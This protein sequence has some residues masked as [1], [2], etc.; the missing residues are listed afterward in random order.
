M[1]QPEKG[2]P[3]SP[4]QGY[5][6]V[7]FVQVPCKGCKGT[8]KLGDNKCYHCEG[9]GDDYKIVDMSKEGHCG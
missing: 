4:A 3:T 2:D 6:N 1:S 5:G 9:T 7:I 8:G